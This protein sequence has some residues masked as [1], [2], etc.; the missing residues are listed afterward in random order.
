MNSHVVL[1]YPF[2]LYQENKNFSNEGQLFGLV[3]IMRTWTRATADPQ[4]T[5]NMGEK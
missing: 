1:S 2:L 4:P 3:V 5:C